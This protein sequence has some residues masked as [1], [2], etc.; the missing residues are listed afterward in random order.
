MFVAI[1]GLFVDVCFQICV[2]VIV[3][4]PFCFW[5]AGTGCSYNHLLISKLAFPFLALYINL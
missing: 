4:A 1:V 3:L 5:G 2:V